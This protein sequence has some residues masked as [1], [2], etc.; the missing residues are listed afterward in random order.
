MSHYTR[1]RT[2]LRDTDLLAAALRALGFPEVEVH[3][4]PQKLRGYSR[5]APEQHAEVVVRRESAGQPVFADLG[6]ARRTDGCFEAVVDA[7]DAARFGRDWT[8]RLTRAY[9]Y[10]AALRYAEAHGYDVTADEVEADG[11]RRLTLRRLR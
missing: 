2:T 5:H 6:F 4:A 1:V 7:S 3:A 10:A 8:A 9:G 11:T